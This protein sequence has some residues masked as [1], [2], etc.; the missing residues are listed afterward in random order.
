MRVA[1]INKDILSQ[2]AHRT[3]ESTL[4]RFPHF[5]DWEAGVKFPTVNQ[6]HK[7]AKALHIPFG[8][9]FLKALPERE[10]P[11]PHYRTKSE[12]TFKPS[13]ELTASIDLV[14]QRQTWAVDLLHELG[15][16]KLWFANSITVETPVKQAVETLNRALGMNPGWAKKLSTWSDALKLLRNKAEEA[17]VF[18]VLNGVVGNNTHSSLDVEEFRG[19]V[20]YHDVAP[21]V[22]INNKDAISGK[23]FTLVHELVHVLL[24]QSASFDLSRLQPADS[25]MEQF[26]DA[27][28]AEFLVPE[29][30]LKSF[31]A[32]ETTDYQEL[33]RHF[34]VSQIVI[35]RRMLDL[36][37]I[38]KPSFFDF[39]NEYMQTEF[40][41]KKGGG[42]DFYNTAP[43]RISSRFFSLVNNAVQ[44]NRLL[45][46]D[47]FRLTG[48]KAKTYDNYVQKHL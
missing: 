37:L 23:I 13:A 32:N 14:Q 41:A 45:Y 17:G 1:N 38:D 30:E 21:F 3:E 25:E 20:L 47:A 42:G 16:E 34:K 29:A 8:Y 4:A 31:V 9:F 19:F 40:P 26:C 46:S 36:G 12:G 39:Y 10:F 6:L 11:I 15:H 44:S 22:F 48:L 28:T 24:G 33:A 35:A 5:Y 27:V 18:V 7:L 43:Y 2:L